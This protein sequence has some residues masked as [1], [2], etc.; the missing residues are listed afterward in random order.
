MN[1]EALKD[2]KCPKC[3]GSLSERE[4]IHMCRDVDCKFFISKERFNQIV[5]ERYDKKQIPEQDP[6]DRLSELNNYGRPKIEYGD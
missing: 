3:G 5:N 6:D 1:W 4:T 2:F